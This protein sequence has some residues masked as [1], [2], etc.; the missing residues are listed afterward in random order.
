MKGVY[1]PVICFSDKTGLTLLVGLIIIIVVLG[2]L[3][4]VITPRH[5]DIRKI[6]QRSAAVPNQ[7][8]MSGFDLSVVADNALIL[9]ISG[10]RYA[11]HPGRAANGQ[12]SVT[13][14]ERPSW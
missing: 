14:R 10:Y 1:I 7:A 3:A 9:I 13:V 11:Y 5:V 4:A 8:N 12:P 2:I 6:A